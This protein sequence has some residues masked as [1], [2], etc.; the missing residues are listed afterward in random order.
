MIHCGMATIKGREIYAKEA[1]KS[2]YYQVESITIVQN[3]YFN[4]F[5]FNDPLK[6]INVLN[7]KKHGF[8][9]I[10][11]ANK[12]RTIQKSEYHLSID[13]D[14]IYHHSFVWSMLRFLMN[15]NTDVVSHHGRVMKQTA[16]DYYAD[17][18]FVH[19]CTLKE[20]KSRKVDFGGTGCMLIDNREKWI[21]INDFH[22]SNMADIFVGIK[23]KYC[24][25]DIWALKHG[26]EFINLSYTGN[27]TI[28]NK[29]H[30]KTRV[31]TATQNRY[32]KLW[33]EI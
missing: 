8:K 22:A 18:L 13:D 10:G 1:I 9:D 24:K 2:I 31:K 17:K 28:W 29:D 25:K 15:E 6:K 26:E 14:L 3:D 27:D 19:R 11:D 33:Q 7:P 32:L 21:S 5:L 12:F 23:A 30:K 16:K 20:P 4:P